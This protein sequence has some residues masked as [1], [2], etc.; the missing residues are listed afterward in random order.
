MQWDLPLRGMFW[1]LVAASSLPVGAALGLWTRPSRRVTSALMAFGGGALLFALT[2]E[3][4]GH[5]LHAAGD[6][7]PGIEDPWILAATMAGAVVGGVLFELLN[8]RLNAQGGFMRQGALLRKHVAK[9]KRKQAA[10]LLKSLSK[11]GLL[12]SLP[13]EEVIQ[14]VP[15]V[16]RAIFEPGQRIFAEGEAG[17]RLYFIIEGK[18]AITRAGGDGSALAVATL[19]PTDTF[20]EI[21]LVS[22]QPRTATATAETAVEVWELLREDFEACLRS[23]PALQAAAQRLARERIQDL[24]RRDGVAPDEA[25]AWE[26]EALRNL[27][28]VAVQTT[29]QDVREEIQRHGVQASAGRAIWLGALLDGI[30]ESIIIG[31]LVVAASAQNVSL[32]LAFILGVFVSNLPE[33]MSSAAT[34]RMG[35]MSARSIAGLWLSL[36]AVAAVFGFA[37]AAVFPPRPEGWVEYAVFAIEGLG[38]GAMLCVIAEAMLPEAFEQGGGSMVGLATL[39]GF[40]VALSVKLLQ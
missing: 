40:L 27:D 1:A 16:R 14:L 36:V 30:P 34:M 25:R 26:R 11:V 37:S 39:A 7:G 31:M 21:A 22:N 17:D 20:G 33:S 10:V 4:F 13:A 9:E 32:G 18:V 12:Q 3:L 35:G 6:G 15:H 23:S 24:S 28:R 29:D 19:G 38:A 5:A 8:R 2:L